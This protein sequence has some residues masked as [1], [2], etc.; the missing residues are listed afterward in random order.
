MLS[1]L[2]LVKCPRDS[3][4]VAKSKKEWDYGSFHVRLFICP[5]C[6]KSFKAYYHNGKLSHTIPTTRKQ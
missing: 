4:E 3:T 2:S 5:K 6:E 1:V